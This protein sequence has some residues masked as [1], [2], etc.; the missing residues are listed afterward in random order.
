MTRCGAQP[1][2]TTVLGRYLESTGAF[3][4]SPA[5]RLDRGHDGSH[6][7]RSTTSDHPFSEVAADVERLTADGK[8]V[9]FEKWTCQHCGARQTMTEPN[10][11]F[12]TGQCE[13]CGL[14]TDITV[15]GTNFI[16]VRSSAGA[17]VIKEVLK[18]MGGSSEIQ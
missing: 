6:A 18:D 4:A 11:W 16:L 5:C 17:D 8:T 3:D 2:R 15:N 9:C 12:T 10:K 13:E 7:Y 1:D 14:V